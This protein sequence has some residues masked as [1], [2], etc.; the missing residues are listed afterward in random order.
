MNTIIRH[1]A[2]LQCVF[3]GAKEAVPP[4]KIVETLSLGV[5][6]DEADCKHK[7]SDT[8]VHGDDAPAGH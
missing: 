1:K 2:Y 5:A 7:C 4:Y 3:R 8:P 6:L